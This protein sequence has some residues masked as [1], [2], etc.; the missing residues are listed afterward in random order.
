MKSNTILFYSEGFY[1]AVGG[2]E[3][4][5]MRLAKELDRQGHNVAVLT[6]QL[7]KELKRE[8]RVNGI[9]VYR[10]PHP[11]M[12]IIGE[13]VGIF[14]TLWFIIRNLKNIRLLHIHGVGSTAAMIAI[15][16]TIFNF[17]VFVHLPGCETYSH[18]YKNYLRRLFVWNSIKLATCFIA[19]SSEIENFLLDLKIPKEKI[20]RIPYG[21]VSPENIQRI[22]KS[23][24]TNYS[25]IAVFVGRLVPVHKGLETLLPAWKHVCE[26]RDDCQLW[27]VGDGYFRQELESLARN[28]DISSRIKFWGMIED[29]FPYLKTADLFVMASNYE[30]LPIA[31]LEAMSIGSTIAVTAVSGALDIIEHE[32]NGLLVPPQKP[33]ALADAIETVFDNPDLAH[34]MGKAAEETIARNFSMET[35]TKKHLDVYSSYINNRIS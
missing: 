21:V 33:E 31:L 26:R 5:V 2:S 23:N 29:V 16:G 8:E 12:R 6:Y 28:L 7:T 24:G 27:I 4:F 17:N 19:I 20:V 14:N 9:I 22:E 3:I 10:V 15:L 18:N 30:G 13:F 32:R 11:G 25:K 34:R 35:I 1:P